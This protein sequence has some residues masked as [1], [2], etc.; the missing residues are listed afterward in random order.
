MKT[1]LTILTGTLLLSASGCLQPFP[2]GTEVFYDQA[3][4]SH[5]RHKLDIFLPEVRDST[6]ATIVMLHGGGWVA[7]DK[8]GA[9]MHNIRNEFLKAGFA[10][11]SM[12]YRYG[13]GDFRK[14]MEDVHSALSL[15]N[16]KAADWKI[17]SHRFQLIGFS[18][19]G[20]LS[21]LYAHAFDTINEIRSVISVVGPTDLTDTV[22]HNYVNNY[23]IMWAVEELMGASFQN[24]PAEYAAASPLYRHSDCPSLFI[25]GALDNLV[26]AAHGIAMFDSLRMHNIGCDT[27]IPAQGSHNVNGPSNIYEVRIH[28]KLIE[29]GVIHL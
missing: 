20:H 22:F 8:G 27:V 18:A 11:A 12:N 5:E 17:A 25:Y 26:P 16:A 4:G 7:G 21:L 13:C 6:T 15:I 2:K 9:E 23:G 24:A 3:Y 29:W 1:F 14:Q 28:T 10:V 19:G